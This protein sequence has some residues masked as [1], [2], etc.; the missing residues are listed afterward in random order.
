MDMERVSAI[1]EMDRKALA[2]LIVE[3][4]EHAAEVGR[5]VMLCAYNTPGIV[6]EY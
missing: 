6:V 5:A 4:V 2:S 1:S 3:L